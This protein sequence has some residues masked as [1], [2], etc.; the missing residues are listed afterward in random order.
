MTV[1][2]NQ[3]FDGVVVGGRFRCGLDPRLGHTKYFKNGSNDCPP[4]VF[5]FAGLALQVAGVGINDQ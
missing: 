4:F 1:Q 3:H 2:Y 5:R